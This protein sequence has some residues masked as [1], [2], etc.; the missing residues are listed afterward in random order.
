[1]QYCLKYCVGAEIEAG[2]FDVTYA[3]PIIMSNVSCLGIEEKLIEC[4]YEPGDYRFPLVS[5][6]CSPEGKLF[7][8]FAKIVL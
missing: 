5:V 2:Y 8:Y 6:A 1:M 4:I 3:L 7:S